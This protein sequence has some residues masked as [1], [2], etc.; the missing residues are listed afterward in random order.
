MQWSRLGS[1]KLFGQALNELAKDCANLFVI[2]ADVASSAGLNEF[3][4][5][6]PS[7]FYN[8]GISEQNMIAMAS[9]MALEGSNVFVTSFAPFASLRPFEAIKS[10]VGSMHLNVKVVSLASGF[11]LGVQGNSHFALDDIAVMRTIPGMTI[12]SP[13]DC[14]ETVKCIDALTKFDGPAYL[15]LTGLAGA[16]NVHKEDYDFSIGKIE[17]V[18]DGDNV[19]ILATGAV[20]NE[21][22][23][24]S[25]LLGKD[26]VSCSVHNVHTL[27]P[28]DS[29]Y[30]ENLA[31]QYKLIVTV[32]EHGVIG[33]LG[34]SVAEVVSSLGLQNVVS[35]IGVSDTHLKDGDYSF[36]LDQCGLS[37]AKIRE[38][39]LNDY[40]RL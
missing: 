13:S 10:L 24:A 28:L 38:R 4:E 12:L 15:R 31:K 26:G 20:I 35:R 3:C 30:I 2:A 40:S 29:L 11:S 18:K 8:T 16:P 23:R 39:I 36:L 37:S 6:H 1:R 32:E 33:G 5:E 17:K 7:Q 21:C 14:V 25:R 27:K 22:I 19:A 34:S 9:G